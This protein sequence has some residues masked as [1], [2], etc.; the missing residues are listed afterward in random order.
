LNQWKLKNFG[1]VF[2][3]EK[4]EADY[5]VN[6]ME[7]HIKE[8]GVYWFILVFCI[9]I[10]IIVPLLYEVT[11][12][13]QL[14]FL[15]LFITLLYAIY[16]RY[17]PQVLKA[18]AV[19]AFVF[20]MGSVSV[21]IWGTITPTQDTRLLVAHGLT[22]LFLIGGINCNYSMLYRIVSNL[23]V[24]A[25]GWLPFVSEPNIPAVTALRSN[26]TI[27]SAF[28]IVTL[29]GMRKEKTNRDIFANKKILEK[30]LFE[31][32]PAPVAGRL[33]IGD[34]SDSVMEKRENGI[35]LFADL[36]GFSE[37]TSKI[38]PEELATILDE[39]F[40]RFD[41]IAKKIG[42]LKIKTIGDAY[43]CASGVI[44]T[45]PGNAK[46]IAEMALD[47]REAMKRYRYISKHELYLRV[48]IAKGPLMAGMVGRSRY[49]FD[50]WGHTVNIAS[51]LEGAAPIDQILVTATFANSLKG[52]FIFS[53]AETKS[54]KGVGNIETYI[55]EGP[56]PFDN[57][58][59]EAS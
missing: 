45:E 6:L 49:Q 58:L 25:I 50:L 3:D 30:V 18:L 22:F 57:Q 16:S 33:L 1:Q 43:M 40:S 15:P 17:I 46:E 2:S 21:Y 59:I 36:A 31:V 29:F 56:V 28:V 41:V 8:V 19:R 55:L 39:V 32:L 37:L 35:V 26:I 10:L 48:G 24:I 9:G 47:M 27:F 20:T 38:E 51:R 44:G 23:S 42:V 12:I 34:S 53:N 14:G 7:Q 11:L 13:H 54:L 5:Q 52:A 4:I